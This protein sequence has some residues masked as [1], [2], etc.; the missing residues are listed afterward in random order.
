[1]TILLHAANNVYDID[2]TA[3]GQ[4]EGAFSQDPDAQA[5]TVMAMDINAQNIGLYKQLGL[6]GV[7]SRSRFEQFGDGQNIIEEG[8][9]EESE[10]ESFFPGTSGKGSDKQS[11]EHKQEIYEQ[12]L[13][14]YQQRLA[15]R[16]S[17]AKKLDKYGLSR[18]Y[19]RSK[20][21]MQLAMSRS[22]TRS[23]S[24]TM[25][26]NAQSGQSDKVSSSAKKKRST[27]EFNV[28]GYIKTEV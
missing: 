14:A 1:M 23:N 20:F 18:D 10:Y 5:F 27:L 19:A 6:V 3:S 11:D 2:P 4:F 8:S 17:L 24:V 9:E 28:D 15:E 7:K 16:E 12:K 25:I 26:P 13:N 22:H 21:S